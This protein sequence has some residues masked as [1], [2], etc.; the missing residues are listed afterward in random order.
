LSKNLA[1][2]GEGKASND[3]QKQRKGKIGRSKKLAIGSEG[4][5]EHN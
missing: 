4:K 3:C 1:I 2:G 5:N